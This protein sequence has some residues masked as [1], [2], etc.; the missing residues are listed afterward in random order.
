[1]I[2]SGTWEGLAAS[3]LVGSISRSGKN[4]GRE[5]ISKVTKEGGLRCYSMT[6][7]FVTTRSRDITMAGGRVDVVCV[8]FWGEG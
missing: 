7:S 5:S 8:G 2:G 1:M 3:A 4:E 6:G